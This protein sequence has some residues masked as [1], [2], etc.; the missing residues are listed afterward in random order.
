M[1]DFSKYRF[2]LNRRDKTKGLKAIKI[3]NYFNSYFWQFVIITGKIHKY[4]QYVITLIDATQ[5]FE[6][7]YFADRHGAVSGGT[8]AGSQKPKTQTKKPNQNC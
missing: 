6:K 4:Q 2:S 5:E 8:S 3:K 7:E 1:I